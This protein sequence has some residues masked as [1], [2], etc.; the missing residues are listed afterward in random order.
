MISI[1]IITFTACK[2]TGTPAEIVSPVIPPQ[3]QDERIA[4]EYV[5]SLIAN[6]PQ[7]LLN[8][9]TVTL[10]APPLIEDDI[11]YMPLEAVTTLLGGTYS[12]ADSV[13][14]ISLFGH[15]SIYEIGSSTLTVDGEICGTNIP[16]DPTCPILINQIVYVPVTFRPRYCFNGFYA[17]TEY[18]P[19]DI[20]I[21]GGFSAEQGTREIQLYDIFD[22]LPE[23]ARTNLVSVGIVDQV[24]NYNIEK[25]EAARDER[26]HLGGGIYVYVL[27]LNEESEEE[28]REQA[29]GIICAIQIL[30]GS[31]ETPR[32]LSAQDTAYRAICLYGYETLTNTFRYQVNGGSVESIIFQTRY[33]GRAL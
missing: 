31:Y 15:V 27:R 4:S 28:D 24:L 2:D 21:L 9:E 29:D 17:C 16:D 1:G 32:G 25:Y 5:L 8:G 30:P 12:Y 7:A 23:S 14:T 10:S 18:P 33:Y 6:K 11:F 19:G 20:A 22:D 13:A 26:S 3:E